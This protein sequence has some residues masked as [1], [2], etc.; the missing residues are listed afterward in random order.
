[1]K[2]SSVNPYI[3]VAIQS[4]LKHGI[5]KRIIFDYE[6]IYL[7]HGSFTF[8]Y[9]DIAYN[10]RE[11]DIIFIFPGISH[12]FIIDRGEI[13][14]PHIHFDISHNVKSESTP[15]SFKDIN[16]M[17][18]IE[19]GYVQKNYFAELQRSPIVSFKDT[20]KFKELFFDIITKRGTDE[21]LSAKGKLVQILSL[22][23]RDNFPNIFERRE[24]YSV[25]N[26]V[27]DYIDAGHGMKMSLD[28]FAVQFSYSKF[29]LE[30]RFKE[31][32]GVCLIEYRNQVRL[33]AAKKLLESASVTSVADELGFG[34]IYAFSR[35][36]KN[37]FGH[38]P[39]C[40]N[41]K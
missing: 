7:E 23:I 19:L 4:R 32:F 40:E 37:R 9:N 30:K 8:M 13:S 3:R 18:E 20:E 33:E 24:T 10:C 26:Q 38:S 28:D 29:H 16:E 41:C 36:Y 27:K 21:E 15:I 25:E 39:R 22:L 17:N 5:A 2:L 6:L 31:R 12:Q 34:S 11:G 14:Q 1:M 35:A